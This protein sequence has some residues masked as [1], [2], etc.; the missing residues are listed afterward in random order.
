MDPTSLKPQ[1]YNTKM[2]TTETCINIDPDLDV[3]GLTT[4]DLHDL[5]KN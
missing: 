1:F 2:Q 3:S 5:N 4:L